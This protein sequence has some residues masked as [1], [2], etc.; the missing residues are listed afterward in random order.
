VHYGLQ[1]PS[2]STAGLHVRAPLS[3]VRRVSTAPRLVASHGGVASIALRLAVTKHSNM[4]GGPE[5]LAWIGGLGGAGAL[6]KRPDQSARV[7]IGE[8]V[9]EGSGSFR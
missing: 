4:F 8:R 9:S 3:Y 5:P 2:E 7:P 6:L 1:V